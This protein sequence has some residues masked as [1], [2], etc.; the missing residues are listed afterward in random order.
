MLSGEGR[1]Q[2]VYVPSGTR[3]QTRSRYLY[4]QLSETIGGWANDLVVGGVDQPG[5]RKI[6]SG[7][8]KTS[9]ESTDQPIGELDPTQG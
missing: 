1:K 7:P 4:Y 8:I 9:L 5:Y 2:C 3:F 6:Q